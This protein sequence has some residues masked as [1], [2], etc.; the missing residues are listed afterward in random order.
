MNK[1]EECNE[2]IGCI[3]KSES[4]VIAPET[5]ID[6]GAIPLDMERQGIQYPKK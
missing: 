4:E 6:S 2:L 1:N 5:S 3:R